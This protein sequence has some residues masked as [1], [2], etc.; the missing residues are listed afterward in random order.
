MA[1]Y[2]YL[3][4]HGRPELPGNGSYCIGN[5]T[6]LPLSVVGRRQAEALVPA[7]A[8]ASAIWCSPLRRSRETAEIMSGGTIPVQELAGLDEIGVGAWEGRSFAEIRE[9]WPDVYDRRGE[10]WSIPPVG[11]ES[12]AAAAGRMQAALLEMTSTTA[13]NIVAVSHEGS[14]RALVWRL[15]GLD[16]RADA[17]YRQPY[18][19]LT[20]IKYEYGAFSVTAAGKL[21]DDVPTD[22][23]IEEMWTRC[24]TPQPVQDHC[25]AVCEEC[26]YIFELLRD[27]GHVLSWN[28]IRAAALLH[29]ACRRSGHDHPAL[30]AALLREQGYVKAARLVSHH[31]DPACMDGPLDGVAVLYLADKLI[32][33]DQHVPLMQRFANSLE[34]CKTEEAKKS[35]HDQ[36]KAAVRIRE[37]VEAIVAGTKEAI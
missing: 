15:M 21:A 19:S 37:R 22:E 11:G 14:I 23:E 12:L 31:H 16:T 36:Y 24:A 20:V 29:D 32:C 33:G 6:D 2:I 34:K 27:A 28:P 26:R 7:F 9:A 4:R 18:G 25:R 17:M 30:A 1:Q 8:D 13:G 35:H 3:I 5:G 10:D